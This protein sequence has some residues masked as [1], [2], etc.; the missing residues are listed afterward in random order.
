MDYNYLTPVEKR[1]GIYFKRDDLFAPFGNG[2][3]NGGKLRQAFFII[4]K[5]IKENNIKGVISGSSI[6]SPQSPI[7]SSVAKYYNIDNIIIY[8]GVDQENLF[9]KPMPLLCLKND[10]KF[11]FVNSGRHSVIYNKAKKI[12]EEN[13]YFIIEYGMNSKDNP[14]E[15]FESNAY[16]VKNIPD[17][18]DDLVVTCG[19]GITTAGILYGI[20]KY[21]KNIKNINIVGVAPNRIE[22]INKR[23]KFL[24][25]NID[26]NYIDLF[27]SRGF[28]YEKQIKTKYYL[29]D[30]HPNYESKV[31]LWTMKNL[32]IK[33]KNVLFW[34]IGGMPCLDAVLK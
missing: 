16:Q 19:S 21:K 25:T 24:N 18:L 29:I 5:K 10:A 8:G 28:L 7:I 30:F 13:G 33:N 4:E 1:G 3:V 23:L 34:I 31:F 2:N 12:Q 26:Y 6:H 14:Y 11:V 20:K 32:E 9:K 17:N 22:K 15:F 27:S